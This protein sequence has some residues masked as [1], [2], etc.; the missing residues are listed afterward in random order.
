MSSPSEPAPT[1]AESTPLQ[2][3][4]LTLGYD[5][6]EGEDDSA[7]ESEGQRYRV[8]AA[9]KSTKL[10]IKES[11]CSIPSILLADHHTQ[12]QEVLH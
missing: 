11:V 2:N 5:T 8:V 12:S 10:E 1:W 9:A 7:D 6:T 3:Y 4:A